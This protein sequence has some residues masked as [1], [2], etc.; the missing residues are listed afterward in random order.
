MAVSRF[1]WRAL[2]FLLVLAA[3]PAPLSAAV[4]RQ[5][6]E[7]VSSIWINSEPR[8]MRDLRGKVVLV[9]FWTFGC[10]NCRNVE[11]QIKQWHGAYASRGLVVI[12]IHTPEFAYEKDAESV[13]RYVREH[14]L[15]YPVVTDNDFANWNRYGNHYWPALY[16]IDK[17]GVIR[18]IRVGEGGY[19]ETERMIQ[20]LLAETE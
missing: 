8:S 6:P 19:P 15:S 18:Y 3:A 17:R 9:E 10:Y 2:V 12:G 14:E 1:F 13:K 20:A 4:G 7:I 11:P 16:L 5:A